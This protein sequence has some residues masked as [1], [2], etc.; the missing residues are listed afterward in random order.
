[1]GSH[2]G[3]L[4]NYQSRALSWCFDIV[5]RKVPRALGIEI[6]GGWSSHHKVT[7]YNYKCYMAFSRV[8]SEVSGKA[9]AY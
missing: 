4:Y 3:L 7:S 5:K 6:T 9:S 1:M 8:V 2:R